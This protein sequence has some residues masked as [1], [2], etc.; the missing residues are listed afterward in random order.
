MRKNVL[1]GVLAT[2]LLGG[3]AGGSSSVKLEASNS[4]SQCASGMTMKEIPV[5]QRHDYMKRCTAGYDATH[6]SDD[7]TFKLDLPAKDDSSDPR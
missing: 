3:C 6:A 4:P 2:V 1:I 5:E 7:D